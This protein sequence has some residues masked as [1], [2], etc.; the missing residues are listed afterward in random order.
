[1]PSPK[2]GCAGLSH[3]LVQEGGASSGFA[4]VR[5]TLSCSKDRRYQYLA[6]FILLGMRSLCSRVAGALDVSLFLSMAQSQGLT[7]FKEELA[8]MRAD[9]ERESAARKAAE[10]IPL[11]CVMSKML[12]GLSGAG[13]G[14]NAPHF[15][16]FMSGDVL[17]VPN[18]SG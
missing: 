8:Q 9:L 3:D 15:V 16:R 7:G 13:K 14:C 11:A 17:V 12:H 2:L 18:F 5:E 10:G 1:M 6:P 4:F